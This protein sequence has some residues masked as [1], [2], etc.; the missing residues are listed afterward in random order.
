MGAIAT[1]FAI[2]ALIMTITFAAILLSTGSALSTTDAIDVVLIQH[3]EVE[4][5]EDW[6]DLPDSIGVSVGKVRMSLVREGSAL[7]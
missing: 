1:D 6:Y 2:I 5:G 7:T 4:V 3:L